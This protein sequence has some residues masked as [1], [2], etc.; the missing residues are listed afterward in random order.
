MRSVCVFCGS[1]AGVQPQYAESTR[2]LARILVEQRKRIIYGAA[3]IGLMGVLANEALKHGGEVI[4]V[5]P[6]HLCSKEVMHPQLS[7]IH[8]TEDM[9]ARKR[10]MMELSDAF[11]ALPGGVGTYDELFEVLSWVQLGLYEKPMGLVNTQGYFDPLIHLLQHTVKE[12]FLH[13][14]HLNLLIQAPDPASLMLLLE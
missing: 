7:K 5:I 9:M 13:P 3:N 2:Q 14:S 10:L 4:G 8:I 1:K 11:I 12:G 6:R